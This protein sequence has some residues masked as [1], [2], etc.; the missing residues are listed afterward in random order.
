MASFVLNLR[1]PPRRNGNAKRNE[2]PLSLLR[3]K[4]VNALFI[5]RAM[6]LDLA[7]VLVQALL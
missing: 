7:F 3:V 2:N 6:T 5:T 4:K 1:R